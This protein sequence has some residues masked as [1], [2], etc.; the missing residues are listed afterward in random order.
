MNRLLL[1][2]SLLALGIRAVSIDNY[3]V[4]ARSL[5]LSHASVSFSD[6]WATFNNQAGLVD[7]NSISTGFYYEPRFRTNGL[8]AG[9]LV[10]PSGVG[11]FGVSFFQ[12]GKRTYKENKFGIA[13]S[14]KLS[15]QLNFGIQFDYMLLTL[16]ENEQAK[17]FITFEGGVNFTVSENLVLGAHIF[18]PFQQGIETFSGKQKWPVIFKVGGSYKFN[19]ITFMVLELEK[20]NSNPL[21]LKTGIEFNPI[22]NLAFRFG[23]SGKPFQYTAGIGYSLGKIIADIGFGYHEN[24]GVTPSVSIQFEF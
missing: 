23:V 20:N 2:I 16:P 11:N 18:N 15:R 5:A 19:E 1:T 21:L 6:V 14:K 13:Y 9:S 12:F 22:D 10:I 4:G 7:L 24:L 17:G 8:Y 3:P